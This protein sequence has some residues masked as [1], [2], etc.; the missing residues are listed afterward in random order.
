MEIIKQLLTNKWKEKG[1]NVKFGLFARVG[2]CSSFEGNNKIGKFSYFCGEIGKYSY[3]GDNAV[4]M[5]RIG[6]FTSVSSSVHTINGHHPLREPYVSTSPVL[7]AK[8][9]PVNISF[10]KE[11]FYDEYTYADIL[12]K[13]P[14]VVGN[15]CWIGYGASILEGVT[16]GDGAVVLAN[17]TVTKDVP[18]FAIVGGVP[19][20]V[21][22]FR[23][24]ESI[25][26]KL[27]LMKW[28]E[29]EEAWIKEN[30]NLFSNIE[31]FLKLE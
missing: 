31:D 26:S 17:A 4:F 15:D 1:K 30:A 3:V 28:W 9:T 11:Q 20:K 14:V 2:G 8:Q 21:I 18:P 5:G 16:I 27:L 25:I 6:R 13:Q 22:G 19:S 12:K 29:K 7:Y 23:Y 10:V 24:E